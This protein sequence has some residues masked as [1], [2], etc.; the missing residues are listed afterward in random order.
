MRSSPRRRIGVYLGGIFGGLLL[1]FYYLGWLWP[2]QRALNALVFPL[3]ERIHQAGVAVRTTIDLR[4][5]E[6]RRRAEACEM[7]LGRTE[8]Q[9][10]RAAMLTSE[11]DELRKLVALKNRLADAMV[12]AEVVGKEIANTQ[13]VLLLNKGS[14]AGLAAGQ[15]V[16]MGDGTLVGRIVKAAPDVSWALLITDSQSKVAATLLNNDH[17]LGVVEGGNGI[18]VRMKFIPR[19]ET[20]AVGERVITSGLEENIPRGLFIGTVAVVENESFQPFQQALVSPPHDLSKVTVVGV[21]T[22]H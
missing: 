10:A 12:A 5:N 2:L 4:P 8:T 16:V 20:V 18:S 6:A 15:P 19:N 7:Q 11:N 1:L 14:A 13:Q 9:A 3:L 17:S 21:L 22:Y